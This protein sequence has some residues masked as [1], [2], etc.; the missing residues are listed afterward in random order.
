MIKLKQI[1]TAILFLCLPLYFFSAQPL[2]ACEQLQAKVERYTTLKRKGGTAIQMNRWSRLKKQASEQYYECW[3]MQ[4]KIQRTDNRSRKSETIKPKREPRRLV[5]SDDP[6]MQQ[7]L[8]T[9]NFW[10]DTYN[11]QPDNDNKSF[12]DTACRALDRA[13]Q[14]PPSAIFNEQAMRRSVNECIKPGN[15]LD[16]D[17][18]ACMMGMREPEWREAVNEASGNA[19]KER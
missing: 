9:C 7:L 8:N 17:V 2:H 13:E 11:R 16:D 5:S 14:N 4:P 18:H 1:T 19:R 12:R 15:V 6:V 3:R 10:I